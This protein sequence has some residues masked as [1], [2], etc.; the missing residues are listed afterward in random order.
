MDK[1]LWLY[2]MKDCEW[3]PFFKPILIGDFQESSMAKSFHK[4]TWHDLS[5]FWNFDLNNIFSI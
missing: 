1:K 5:V 3:R 4:M 2:Q